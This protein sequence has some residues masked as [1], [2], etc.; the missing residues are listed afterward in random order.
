MME[1]LLKKAGLLKLIVK[2]NT[3]LIFINLIKN[4]KDILKII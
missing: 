2:V 4:K 1:N 3:K